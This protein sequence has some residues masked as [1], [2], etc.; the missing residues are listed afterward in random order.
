MPNPEPKHASD[1]AVHGRPGDPCVFVIFG[2]TGDLTKVA[3]DS[4]A[5][6]SARQQT[7]ARQV[8]DHRREQREDEFRDFRKQLGDEIGQFTTTKVKPE[9]WKWFDQRITYMSGD[10]K[11]PAT[12]TSLK[13]TLESVDKAHGTPGNYFVLHRGVSK[14]FR[15]DR[16]ATGRG[17]THQRNRRA[18]AKSDHRKAVR[19]RF[20][21]GERAQSRDWRMSA[22]ESDLPN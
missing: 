13:T 9:L 7:V 20:G 8:R 19:S 16:E 6:Q 15:R 22:R 12:Y 14:F 4:V 2:A 3:A 17:G 5:V 18:L 10:F 21:I 1:Q 11:D